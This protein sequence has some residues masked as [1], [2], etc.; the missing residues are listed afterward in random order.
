MP[1]PKKQ[2]SGGKYAKP[3]KLALTPPTLPIEQIEIQRQITRQNT[4]QNTR[5]RH[6]YRRRH[7]PLSFTIIQ[8]GGNGI[9]EDKSVIAQINKLIKT[10]DESKD[11]IK[12]LKKLISRNT[13]FYS[14]QINE[15]LKNAIKNENDINLEKKISLIL[16]GAK[17]SYEKKYVSIILEDSFFDKIL[18]ITDHNKMYKLL[19]LVITNSGIGIGVSD[20]TINKII[21]RI[22]LSDFLTQRQR[23]KLATFMN[24]NWLFY[25]KDNTGKRLERIIKEKITEP[26]EP[27]KISKLLKKLLKKD[28]GNNKENKKLSKEQNKIFPPKPPNLSQQQYERAKS[29]SILRLQ[30][31]TPQDPWA[32]QKKKEQRLLLRKGSPLKRELNQI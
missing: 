9:T 32:F 24:Y 22:N 27:G 17:L 7:G 29:L 1:K 30:E 16:H 31:D 25:T 13:P 21:D 28:K 10:S 23:K 3:L 20:A 8:Q 5:Q 2:L 15:F 6:H 4:R 11:D 12:Q 18:K 19:K 26:K 14:K